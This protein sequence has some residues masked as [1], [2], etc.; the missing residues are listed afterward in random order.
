MIYRFEHFEVDDT[1]FRLSDHGQTLQIEPKAL[2]VL[3]CLLENHNRLIRKQDLLDV[4]WKDAFVTESTLTRTISLLRKTLA[5]D[6]R[7]PRLI[8]TVPTLGYRFKGTV[9]IVSPLS[10][11]AN[12]PLPFR[13]VARKPREAWGMRP[14]VDDLLR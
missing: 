9:E 4:V 14:R 12:E 5:D 1:E 7:E 3:L 13:V 11:R 8:E 2:R 10:A 6:K